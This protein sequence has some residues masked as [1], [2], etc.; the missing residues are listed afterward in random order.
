MAG[1]SLQWD[2]F[3]RVIDNHGDLGVCWRLAR[4]LAAQGQ[5]VRLW[6]DD[7]S[8]LAWMAPKGVAGVE[9]MPW[10]DPM[11]PERPG[12][13]VVEALGCDPPTGFVE[14]MAAAGRPPVW[15]NLEYLSAERAAERNHGLPSPQLGGPG[16]GLRKWFYYPGFTGAT[17]GLLREDG[18]AAARHR[19]DAGRWLGGLGIEATP[20]ARRISLFC[21]EQPALAAWMARW[22]QTPTQLLVTPGFAARQV[23]AVLGCTGAPGST[24]GQGAL[25]VHFL[26]WLPQDDYDRLLWSCDLNLVRGEDSPVRALWAARPF[27]WQLYP[28]QDGAHEAKLEAFLDGH[29]QG[30]S[31]DL[32]AAIA[33]CFRHWNGLVPPPPEEPDPQAWL[34]QARSREARLAAQ[35][36]TSGDLGSQLYRYALSKR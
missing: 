7:A 34:D 11:P 31:D 25:R 22:C 2:L 5:R 32:A 19:F 27:V 21:Y 16:T 24:A 29:L 36:A 28:Q 17:G 14:A 33:G 3:C 4:R 15:I 18:L 35:L 10:R 13:V 9:T 30:T 23:A 1:P 26:P 20:G 12:D 8:A 6:V